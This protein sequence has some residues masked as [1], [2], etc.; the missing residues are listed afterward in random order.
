M[1]EK[2]NGG[3][4]GK[5]KKR[6]MGWS[7]EWRVY[8]LSEPGRGSVVLLQSAFFPLHVV[9]SSF[10]AWSLLETGHDTFSEGPDTGMWN[11][12]RGFG[13]AFPKAELL[14]RN[15][16]PQL[17]RGGLLQP[18][19]LKTSLSVNFSSHGCASREILVV[20]NDDEDGN[21]STSKWNSSSGSYDH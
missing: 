4:K 19:V 11:A 20:N 8:F 9:L 15:A 6:T 1:R 18:M 10:R 16:E 14:A 13:C 7:M 3:S 2:I 5:E 12:G 17:G 21:S